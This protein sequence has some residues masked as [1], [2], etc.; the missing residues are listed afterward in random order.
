MIENL[1]VD[2]YAIEPATS[3]H[4]FVTQL[5]AVVPANNKQHAACPWPSV[6]CLDA[7]MKLILPAD[8]PKATKNTESP[9][10]AGLSEE[11]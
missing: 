5:N 1:F 10:F 8:L 9:G 4:I 3:L 11:K 6:T 2:L 7:R